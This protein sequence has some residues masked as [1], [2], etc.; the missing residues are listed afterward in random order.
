MK[1]VKCIKTVVMDYDKTPEI[2][3]KNEI[4][5][6][7]GKV[8]KLN[9]E[10]ACDEQGITNHTVSPDSDWFEEHF[11]YVQR[12]LPN[13][14][15]ECPINLCMSEEKGDINCKKVWKA[16]FKYFEC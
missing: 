1:F 8:Y 9:G 3:K 7:K 4:A 15:K 2:A 5:Y 11:K 16:I 13:N 12:P 10:D 14:C 6:I